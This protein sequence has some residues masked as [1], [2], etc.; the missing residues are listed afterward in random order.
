MYNVY[1]KRRV[2]ECMPQFG[3]VSK[4][5]HA[6]V[7]VKVD[8]RYDNY[9]VAEIKGFCNK[10]SEILHVSSGGE[11]HLCRVEKV[12]FQLTFQV[13]SFVQQDIFPLSG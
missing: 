11:L 5:S 13:P 10:L 4:T 8:S 9:T 7:F 1:A 3:P 2:Y 6:D 12:C